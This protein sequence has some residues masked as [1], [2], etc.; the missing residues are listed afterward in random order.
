MKKRLEEDFDWIKSVQPLSVDEIKSAL[1]ILTD[2][3]SINEVDSL[4]ESMW[5]IGISNRYAFEDFVDK[6]HDVFQ[7]CYEYASENGWDSGNYEGYEEGREI[8]HQE[9]YE[10]GLNDCDCE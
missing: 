8:G 9:G 4:S 7:S 5:T 3:V 2:F 6:L 10:E 1:H